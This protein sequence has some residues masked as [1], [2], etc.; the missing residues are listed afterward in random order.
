[1]KINDNGTVRDMTSEEIAE[2]ERMQKETPEISKTPEERIAEL[3]K[4]I[5]ELKKEICR[6]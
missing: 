2:M 5:E 6:G 1:M 4:I 3:E